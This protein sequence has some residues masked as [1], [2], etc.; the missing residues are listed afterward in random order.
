[1]CVYIYRYTA[2]YTHTN[3][4][5]TWGKKSFFHNDSLE[6]LKT[7]A[8]LDINNSIIQNQTALIDESQ[9]YLKISRT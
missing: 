3:I 5:Y 8:E 1:M 4:I 2:T 7:R 9:N 6:Y